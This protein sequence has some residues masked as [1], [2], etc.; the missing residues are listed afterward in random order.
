MENLGS[1]AKQEGQIIRLPES[2]H[3]VPPVVGYV[4][5]WFLMH[6]Q[7]EWVWNRYQA[8]NITEMYYYYDIATRIQ[9][10]ALPNTPASADWKAEEVKTI[11]IRMLDYMLGVNPWD[12][13][14][15]YGLVTRTSTI[16]TTG[17]QI[18]RECSCA[19]YRYV[20]RLVRCR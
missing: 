13:S 8:G 19:F 7:M 4:L 16:L 10:I 17:R 6:T 15:I 9:G 18:G 14:M 12:I 2:G 11:L 1:V 3:W 5:P 20:R